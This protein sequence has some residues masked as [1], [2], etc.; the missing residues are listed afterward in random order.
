MNTGTTESK[1]VRLSTIEVPSRLKQRIR[2]CPK[3]LGEDIN[4]VFGDGFVPGS[5]VLLAGSPGAG[6]STL[7]HQ[8]MAASP[9]EA[10]YNTGEE[11]L[12]QLKITTERLGIEANYYVSCKRNVEELFAEVKRV[13]AKLV[14]VDSVQCLH[15][16]TDLA[17]RDIADKSSKIQ[18]PA[19]VEKIYEWAQRDE[20]LVTF[21]L[22]CHM[23]KSGDF[24]GPETV[25]H[26]VDANFTCRYPTKKEAEELPPHARLLSAEKNRFGMSRVEFVMQMGLQ[27]FTSCE[28]REQG[29]E[30]G[31]GTAPKSRGQGQQLAAEV[32][33]ELGDGATRQTFIAAM[34]ERGVKAGTASTYWA[35][36]AFIGK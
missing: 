23:T 29:S 35:N 32:L 36:R 2:F 12:G 4:A 9:V 1:A 8:L 5:T 34:V 17:G 18:L 31:E 3:T 24:A 22:V 13:K 10:L 21:V 25:S 30:D 7:L 11:A 16:E 19:I 15:T 14:V 27:G 33:L 6:K 28:Q 26:I 20:N